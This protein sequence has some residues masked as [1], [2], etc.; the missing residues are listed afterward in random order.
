MENRY[1]ESILCY[2]IFIRTYSLPS[3]S[4]PEWTSYS[5]IQNFEI[6]DLFRNSVFYKNRMKM[7]LEISR[8]VSNHF[9]NGFKKKPYKKIVGF[10][11]LVICWF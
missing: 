7:F 2:L 5:A 8:N 3:E 11:Y 9:Y 4:E 1:F 6:H 10:I